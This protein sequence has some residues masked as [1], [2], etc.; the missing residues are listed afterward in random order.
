VSSHRLLLDQML[1][2]DVAAALRGIGCDVLRVRN[3]GL[4]TAGDDEILARAIADSRVLVTLDEH[5]GDWVVLPLKEHPG[6][7]RVKATPTTTSAILALLLPLLRAHPM[8]AFAGRLVIARKT[9]TR[10]VR[11]AN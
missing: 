8:N 5:F 6:V 4:A 2:E 11:T 7:I 3:V 10:W 1:D 9:G